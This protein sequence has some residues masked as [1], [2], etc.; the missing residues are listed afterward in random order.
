[1]RNHLF[2]LALSQLI[3]FGFCPWAIGQGPV[4]RY[5][6]DE[7][8]EI[9][10]DSGTGIAS[11]GLLG[12]A[13]SRTSSTPGG[14]SAYALD[15][16]AE[17][18]DSTLFV[19]PSPEID[20]L[21]SFTMTTWLYLN[22]LNS[23]QGGSGNVRLLASQA[24]NANFDGF[25]WNLNNP[26]EGDRG[27]DNFSL[28]M[29]IGGE[30]A[31]AF[32]RSLENVNAEDRWVFL[33]VSY[34]GNETV[35]N[36]YFYVGDETVS[37]T[38]LI[39]RQ[40]G[41]PLSVGA[42]HVNSTAALADFGIGFTDA[43]AGIDFSADGYQDDVRVYDRVLT[44]GELEAVRL[45]NLISDISC[46]FDGDGLCNVQDLDQ[47][48][49]S[50]GTTNPTYNLDSTDETITL[51]DRDAWLSIAGDQNISRP[52]VVGDSDLDGDVDAADLNNLGVAW[53]STDNPTWEDGDF[54]A[55]G[56]V[57]A[58][59]LNDVG[60]NWQQGVEPAAASVPE[61][62]TLTLAMV[63]TAW[64]FGWFRKKRRA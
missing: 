43:A 17:G 18:V 46:D 21:E 27:I 60:L 24:G 39:T 63:L 30:D 3:L 15:L 4:V 36:L 26:S 47:L 61:P 16:S 32:G 40:L 1:M 20:A 35:D 29:F 50:L 44:I 34:D 11:D 42:G 62:D 64:T 25:S 55:D 48:L 49:S 9:A 53:L 7:E 59:D 38:E 51:G 5:A 54:D 2:L 37:D 58:K 13:T 28:A 10:V 41:D 52:Y 19:G 8:G 12:A 14:F 23:D 31:F 6:F 22:G 33:A 57:D 45:E 56:T